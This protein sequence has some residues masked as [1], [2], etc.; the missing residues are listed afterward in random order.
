MRR[1]RTESWSGIV[2]VLLLASLLT[3][4]QSAGQKKEREYYDSQFNQYVYGSNCRQLWPSV[5]GYFAKDQF[6]LADP[7]GTD[8]S[9]LVESEWKDTSEKLL[10][11]KRRDQ[12]AV[13]ARDVDGKGCSLEIHHTREATGPNIHGTERRKDRATW[14][15]RKLMETIEPARYQKIIQEGA[16]IRTETDGVK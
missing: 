1:I 9:F 10:T 4:C 15:E 6:R 12:I 14:M 13:Q 5:K 2:T 11:D 16:R 8:K 3:A 7:A